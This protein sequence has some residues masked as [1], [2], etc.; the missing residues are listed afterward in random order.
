M[1]VNH[2]SITS[3]DIRKIRLITSGAAPL[4]PPLIHKLKEK[5][6][7]EKIFLEGFGMTETSAASVIQTFTLENAV[8]VGGSGYLLPNMEAK[9]IPIDGSSLEN[10]PPNQPGELILKGPQIT[11]GYHNNRQ[12]TREVFVDGWLKTGDVAYY[13][14]HEH[15]FISGRLKEIIKVKGFS[16]APAEIEEV[17]R[18]HPCVND[19]AV[20]GIADEVSG[21]APKA[22][23]VTKKPVLKQDLME[24][25]A[26]KVAKHKKLK[27]IVFV[28]MI[29]KAPT[30]QILRRI[31]KEL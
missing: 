1:L 28:K 27:Q 7:N 20:V 26:G 10:L 21:E 24:F 30:G 8:K 11:K 13:D 19:C 12:A 25:V 9:V 14:E 6:L 16:V 22:F 23:V 29:P 15:F 31:L 5:S 17:L 3:E 4:S 2:P 18:Q